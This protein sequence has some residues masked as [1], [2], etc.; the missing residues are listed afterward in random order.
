MR[1]GHPATRSCNGFHGD[2]DAGHIKAGGQLRQ[3][4]AIA[5]AQF[6]QAA[7]AGHLPHQPRIASRND[8]AIKGYPVRDRVKVLG[9]VSAS[10]GPHSLPLAGHWHRP[11]VTSGIGRPALVF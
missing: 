7:G 2:V 9:I 10:N 6:E 3:Q 8:I 1:V 5:A 4:P 11:T